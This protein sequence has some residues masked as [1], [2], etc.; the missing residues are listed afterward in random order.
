MQY[1]VI[2]SQSTKEI[3]MF[4][5]APGTFLNAVFL[6]LAFFIWIVGVFGVIYIL[7]WFTGEV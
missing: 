5:V 2:R 7:M 4:P 6:L 3:E 1:E